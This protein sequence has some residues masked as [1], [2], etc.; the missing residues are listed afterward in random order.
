MKIMIFLGIFKHVIK[1]HDSKQKST[2]AI[3][4]PEYLVTLD[5]KTFKNF[6][7]KYPLSAVDFWASWCAPCKAMSPRLRR[8]SNIY[9]GKVAFGKLDIQE[10]QDITKRYKIIGIPQLIFFRNGK[11]IAN[12]TGSRSIGYIK[13]VI[14]ELLK[15]RDN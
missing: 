7:Q 1:N 8:L 6:I 13:N 5:K 14:E 4:W 9:K 2:S 12:I 3:D 15:K 11:K 10:N